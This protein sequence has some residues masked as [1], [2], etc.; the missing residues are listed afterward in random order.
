MLNFRLRIFFCIL[1]FSFAG[2][3]Y[4]FSGGGSILPDDI[5]KVAVL[6]AVNETAEPRMGSLLTEA[7]RDQFEKFGTFEVVEQESRAD[8]IV[9]SRV[10]SIERGSESVTAGT[11][12]ALQY[13]VKVTVDVELKRKDGTLLWKGDNLAERGVFG[14]VSSVVVE[15]S[16]AFA[17]QGLSLSDL[18]SLGNIELSRAQEEEIFEEIAEKLAKRVYQEAVMPEF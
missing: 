14:G 7:L 18:E 8:A 9:E 12:Q 17:A 1:I 4:T 13:N 2:C 10:K 5:K 3:G 15:S 16:P 6:P 11:E